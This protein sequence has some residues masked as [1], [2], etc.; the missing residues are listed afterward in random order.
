MEN[1]LLIRALRSFDVCESCPCEHPEM[2]E[3]ADCIVIQAADLI[4]AQ[5]KRIAE[6]EA[7]LPIVESVREDALMQRIAE[8]EA[9]MRKGEQE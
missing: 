8:L 6:L 2:C 9:R 4:E 3:N 5:A 1:E 7:E